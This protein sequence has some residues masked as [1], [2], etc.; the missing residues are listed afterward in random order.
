M[1]NVYHPRPDDSGKPVQL[2]NPNKPTLL[3][4][5]SQADSA[6]STVPDGAI[7]AQINGIPFAAWSDAPQSHEAW[8]TVVGQTDIAEPPFNCPNGKDEAAGVVICEPDG[9]IWLVS[10]SNGYGG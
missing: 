9:R 7:S 8:N 3:E 2:K 4:T 6:A 10:P 1:A 5:W